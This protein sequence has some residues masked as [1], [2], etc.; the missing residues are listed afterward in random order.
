MAV[1]EHNGEIVFLRRV[2]PG[3]A[4]RSYGIDVARLAGLPK[5]V[6][7]RAR[8]IMGSLEG[9]HQLGTSAQLSLLPQAPPSPVV[10]RIA[11]IDPNR[12]TPL[13]ALQLLADLKSLV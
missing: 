1:R 7:A 2:V 5:S 13:E 11:A 6:I 10:A 9:G 12:I 4:N 3:G 8:D